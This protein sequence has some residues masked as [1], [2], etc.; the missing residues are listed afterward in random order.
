MTLYSCGYCPY[1]T[2]SKDDLALHR[3]REHPQTVKSSAPYFV[4]LLRRYDAAPRTKEG[5]LRQKLVPK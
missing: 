3:E 5:R 1:R 4:A 2:K